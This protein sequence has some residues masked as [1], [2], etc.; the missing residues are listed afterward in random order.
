MLSISNI[1][2]LI[3]GQVICVEIFLSGMWE[4]RVWSTKGKLRLQMQ[5]VQ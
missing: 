4:I 2:N 3:S 1:L 5:F